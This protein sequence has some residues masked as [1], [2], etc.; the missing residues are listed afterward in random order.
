MT[1]T[2]T[3]N[4]QAKASAPV[5][6]GDLLINR[7]LITDEQ[8]NKALAQ[9]KQ[10]GNKKLLGEILL[11][12]GF[13]TEEDL[14]AS[15]AEAYGIPFARISSRVADPRVIETLPREFLEKHGILPLFKVQGKLTVAVPE[16]SN[17]FLVEEIQRLA[18]CP[19]QLVASTPK[20]IHST[21][22]NYLP[23]ANVFVIDDIVDDFSDDKMSL[24]DNQVADITDLMDE[25]A[26]GESP[27]I[28]LVNYIIYNAVEDGASDIHMEPGDKSLRVRYRVDGSLYEKFRPP[29]QMGP[30]LVSRI[31]IM[32]G[33]DISERRMPQDGAITVMIGKRSV[34]L[35]VSTIPGKVGEKV[36]M[37]VIDTAGASVGLDNLGFSHSMLERWREIVKSPNGI[38]LVTGPTG[39]GKSTTLYAT[40]QEIADETVNVSTVEDPVEYQL[41]GINQFQTNDKAGFTFASALRS[42]LR[43]DPDIIMVGEIRDADTGKIATQAALTGHLVVSTLHTNDAPSAIT[44]MFNIG[45]EP[46]LVAAS[47][48]GVLA[49]RLLRRI[50]KHCKEEAELTPT[51]IRSLERLA[52]GAPPIQTTYHGAGCPKC[53]GR[54]YSGRVGIYELF[55]PDEETLDVVSRGA[56]LQEIKRLAFASGQYTT[57]AQDGLEKVRAGVISVDELLRSASMG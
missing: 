13:V 5:R 44:R 26:A 37:R 1:Q 35:R 40:L 25:S 18:D 6:I 33:L 19:I 36:C 48:K 50:C 34:D 29:Y 39:S 38:V 2:A 56:T 20:D 16:P 53:H 57:I 51:V 43:Q 27:V 31:K 14:L 49:Q 28:K 15:L 12:M 7:G 24:V 42:L 55:A 45:V 3:E 22:Q 46:Y 41:D 32:G 54:G 11:Q 9:Q 47:V 17:V 4:L 10:Q 23:Q 21:L 52:P 8:L 30:A